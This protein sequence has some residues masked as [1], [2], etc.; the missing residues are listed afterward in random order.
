M[1]ASRVPTSSSIFLIAAGSRFHAAGA[2][3]ELG[4]LDQAFD[5]DNN[6]ILEPTNPN[7]NQTFEFTMADG[8]SRVVVDPDPGRALITGDLSDQ[9]LFKIPTL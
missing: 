4:P 2:G 3:F 9:D 6:L 8:S 1:G 5:A 7:A